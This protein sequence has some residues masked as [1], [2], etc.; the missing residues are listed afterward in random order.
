MGNRIAKALAATSGWNAFTA[1]DCPGSDQGKNNSSFSAFAGGIC[2]C[3]GECRAM[4]DNAFFASTTENSDPIYLFGRRI[5]FDDPSLNR[6]AFVVKDSLVREPWHEPS[7]PSRTP[8][9]FALRA[10]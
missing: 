4:G 3:S 6:P 2:D 1:A 8:T 10:N 5:D 7:T 9:G